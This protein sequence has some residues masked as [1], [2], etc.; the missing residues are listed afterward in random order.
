M[1]ELLYANNATTTLAVGLNTTVTTITV[2]TGGGALFPN[3]GAGQFFVATLTDAATGLFNEIVYVTARS[4]DAMTV[5]RAQ[6]GTGARN[7]LVSDVF[8]NYWTAGS[9]LT[10]FQGQTYAGNPNG[11]VAGN[12]GVA[13]GTQ[14]DVPDVLWDS[15]NSTF[16]VC[17]TTGTPTTAV[18][19]VVASGG[20]GS[21]Y[22]LGTST[23][24]ANAQVVTTPALMTSFPTGQPFDFEPGYANT[25]AATI[26]VG[27]FGTFSF[28]KPGTSGPV[29][30]TGGE[31]IVGVVTPCVFDGTYVQIVG[32]GPPVS[33]ITTARLL[34]YGL[35]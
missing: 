32:A 12:A 7:W 15:T 17:T 31:L 13:G 33:S 16:W 22:W 3:P 1:S 10:F 18:W 26:R 20:G 19:T 23:G 35:L 25:G 8:A 24:S 5:I 6:E 4:G 11:F 30:L 14:G 2:A 9:T 21:T 34:Y 29:A 27:A 28:R